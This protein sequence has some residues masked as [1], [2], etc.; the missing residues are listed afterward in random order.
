MADTSKPKGPHLPRDPSDPDSLNQD[1]L[2]QKNSAEK[3][4]AIK[5]DKKLASDKK[6]AR[7]KSQTKTKLPPKKKLKIVSSES[8]ESAQD[9]SPES[10]A[11]KKERER[12]NDEKNKKSLRR[13]QDLYSKGSVVSLAK[14]NFASLGNQKIST[15]QHPLLSKKMTGVMDNPDMDP[16]VERN[17]QARN[18]LQLQLAAKAQLQQTQENRST[19]KPRPAGG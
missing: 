3:N 18:E 16:N 7:E 6:K 13:R 8:I 19:P 2:K 11:Q 15:P 4:D 5:P 12:F 1:P 17:T 9:L 10:L 14:K